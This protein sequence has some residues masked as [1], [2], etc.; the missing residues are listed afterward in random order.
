[1]RRSVVVLLMLAIAPVGYAQEN[2]DAKARLPSVT[3]V[4]AF[5]TVVNNKPGADLFIKKLSCYESGCTMITLSASPCEDYLGGK[6]S[7]VGLGAS[8]TAKGDLRITFSTQSD[9]GVIVAEQAE[10]ATTISY[11]F[12]LPRHFVQRAA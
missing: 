3:L 6:K 12:Y 2:G 10:F 4:A 5:K 9:R 8:S 1:M 7:V 11:V